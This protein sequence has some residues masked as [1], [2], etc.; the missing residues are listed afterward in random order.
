MA[1]RKRGRPYRLP[2]DP[3]PLEAG[4]PSLRHRIAWL[5]GVSRIHSTDP[6]LARR[7][8][9][10][11]RLRDKGLVLDST[12]L[13]RWESGHLPVSRVVM[14]A[15]E[16]VLGLAAGQL[17]VGATALV[18]SRDFPPESRRQAEID[19]VVL[20][21]RL[22]VLFTE[23]LA[24]RAAG[25]L[26]V[27]LAELLTWNPHVYL[28]PDSWAELSER[29]ADELSRST[30]L[31][32]LSR[33]KAERLLVGHPDSRRAAVR[34]IGGVVTNP[35]TEFVT[36]PLT[37]LQEVEDPQAN[38][39][40]LRLLQG[41]PPHRRSGASWAIAAKLQLGQLDTAEIER[42]EAAAVDILHSH[43][44]LLHHIDALNLFLHLPPG[45]RARVSDA[46][47]DSARAA[48]RQVA[49]H[50]E[51]G[52]TDGAQRVSVKMATSVQERTLTPHSVEPDPMLQRLIR[53]ALFHGSH[54]RRHQAALLLAASPYRAELGGPLLRRAS[55]DDELTAV[56]AVTA[57][58]YVADDG[59]R[60]ALLHRGLS[61]ARTSVR[62]GALMAFGQVVGRLSIDEAERLRRA[63]PA[64]G[65][66]RTATIHVL[67]IGAASLLPQMSEGDG[68]I[69]QAARWWG[70]SGAITEPMVRS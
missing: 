46:A 59:Q 20:H 27:E 42:V 4:S 67:G 64:A 26:W 2:A 16:E 36:H 56:A 65:P 50:A 39:L 11:E 33:F 14:T 43:P 28:L 53:E 54:A 66:L 49:N 48:L 29:L 31:A 34:A 30:G 23:V 32:Y 22:D 21:E 13:S 38:D 58:T 19:S 44:S 51:V 70:G 6:G 18:A 60:E 55:S 5:L 25:H 7:D 3:T 47:P 9:F 63:M 1:A 35:M 8:C 17:T 41:G 52:D 68:A 40:L 69:A 45:S 62:V 37:L 24:G 61:D 57:M 12:R 15:Y 10:I